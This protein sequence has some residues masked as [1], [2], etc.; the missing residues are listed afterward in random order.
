[1]AKSNDKERKRRLKTESVAPLLHEHGKVPPQA[2]SLEENILGGLMVEEFRTKG[3]VIARLS[4]D[5]FY[6]EA[7]QIIYKAIETLY[8]DNK[9]TD[10]LSVANQLKSTG[11]LELVGGAFK[12]SKLTN[13]VALPSVDYH[14]MIVKQK[15]IQREVIRICSQAIKDGFE[16]TIDVFDLLD[17]LEAGVADLWIPINVI[18]RK[19]TKEVGA[20]LREAWSSDKE[21]TSE[22]TQVL[23]TGWAIFDDKVETTRNKIILASGSAADGKSR[24]ISTWIFRI[25]KEYHD[26]VSVKWITLEDSSED[27]S[28]YFFSPLTMLTIKE[29]KRKRFNEYQKKY[30]LELTDIYEKFDIDFVEESQYIVDIQKSFEVF[31]QQREKRFNILIIDNILS[32]KDRDNFGSDLNSMYDFVMSKV[33]LIK[34]RTKALII[35]VHHFRD[36]QQDP[37][38]L[39]TG[40]R[41]ALADQKG[42]EAFRRVPNQVLLFNNPSKRK[43]LFAEY[44]GER[45]EILKNIFIVD[46]GKIRDDDNADESSLMYFYTD[47]GYCVFYEIPRILK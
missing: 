37:K 29:L 45:K 3:A 5:H 26:Q 39:R 23:K 38:H 10:I 31:C 16:D 15:F 25:L 27:I 30:L 43:D 14:T 1:M 9:P 19:D 40:Y 36:S 24:F 22:Y 28:T 6:K 42:T 33:L 20:N 18:R 8:K 7:H 35:P 13:N 4:E 47:L 32:L 46:P 41:P 21:V 34:Q 44:Y 17:D 11:E 2:T 12:I